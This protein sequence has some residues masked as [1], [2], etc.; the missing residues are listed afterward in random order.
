MPRA[1]LPTQTELDQFLR[2]SRLT[3]AHTEPLLK[4]HNQAIAE[5]AATSPAGWHGMDDIQT[6]KGLAGHYLWTENLLQPARMHWHF[7]STHV[8]SQGSYDISTGLAVLEQGIFYCVP[9][10]PAIGWAAISLMP[11]TSGATPRSFI[12][13]GM[14]TDSHWKVMSLLLNKLGDHGPLQPGFSAV[15]ML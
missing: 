15:R 4:H 6:L 7:D 5:L 12:V 2:G 8:G 14:L 1:H 10:N 3:T 9:N 13:S 11:T